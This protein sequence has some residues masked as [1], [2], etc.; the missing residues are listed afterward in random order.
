MER[1]VQTFLMFGETSGKKR[2]GSITAIFSFS[3]N[4]PF[5]RLRIEQVVAYM[6][7]ESIS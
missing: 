2:V 6:I 3:G 1:R 4:Y 7:I 5:G